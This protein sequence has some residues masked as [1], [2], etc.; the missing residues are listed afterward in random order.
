MSSAESTSDTSVASWIQSNLTTLFQSTGTAG[1]VEVEPSF[2]QI[3][4]PN[5]EIRRN[6]ETLD[7]STLKGDVTSQAA[8]SQRADVKWEQIISTNVDGPGDSTIIAG[9]FTVTRVMPFRIR[10]S[11]AQRVAYVQFSAKVE[12]QRDGT[13]DGRRITSFYYT[14]VDKTPPIHFARPHVAKVEKQD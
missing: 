4:S 5:C 9:A 14:V 10:A 3:F 11:L 6:H 13:D 1:K 7:L 12:P 8:G 2:D